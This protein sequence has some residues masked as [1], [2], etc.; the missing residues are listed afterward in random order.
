MVFPVRRGLR[1]GLQHV[2]VL[3]DLA[4]VVEA[5]D[6]D[7]CPVA[8][9]GPLLVAM[10]DDVAPLGDGPLELHL[11]AGVPAGHLAEVGDEGL[12]AVGDRG[13]VLDVQVAHVHLDGL[14]GLALV[15]HEVVERHRV[16]LVLV[17]TLGH[18]V[19]SSARSAP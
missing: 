17:R 11:L 19:C 14:G 15:E 4:R 6:V 18:R 13:V 10:E 3:D 9:A 7:A 16:P 1:D 8:V 2:P 12:L 5:K